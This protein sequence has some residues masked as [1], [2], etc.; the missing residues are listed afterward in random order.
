MKERPQERFVFAIATALLAD[1]C[2]RA[3]PSTSEH[4]P[5]GVDAAITIAAPAPPPPPLPEAAVRVRDGV[6]MGRTIAAPMSYLGADWLE[7]KDRDTTQRPEHVLDILGVREGQ[8]VADVGCG[9][10]YFTLHLAKRVGSA[11]RVYA[12]D[13]QDEMLALLRP[14]LAA[15]KLE[16]VT[17]V[18]TTPEDARLPTGSLALILLVDVYHE[19]PD[20][21]VSLAQFAAALTPGTGRLAL[22]EYRAEDPKVAI[23]PEHKTTLVQL[24]REL[25]ANGWLFVASDESLAEQRIVVFRRP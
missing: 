23:K 20:P 18:R 5:S 2:S 12:T 8:A 22:V 21:P 7:R 14:R 10:G 19:L 24:Q 25:A 1:A 11:G 3:A 9:S 17:L 16:N 15:A 13:L 4:P 6:Y